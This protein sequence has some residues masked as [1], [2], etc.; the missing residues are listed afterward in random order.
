[1]SPTPGRDADFMPLLSCAENRPGHKALAAYNLPAW[2]QHPSIKRVRPETCLVFPASCGDGWQDL[3]ERCLQ[4]EAV[5]PKAMDM[6]EL[7]E[8]CFGWGMRSL[9]GLPSEVDVERRVQLAFVAN[10]L[11]YELV[12][13]E[14]PQ[15]CDEAACVAGLL[16]AGELAALVAAEVMS[17]DQGLIV[18]QAISVAVRE[19]SLCRDVA[20]VLKGLSEEEARR[21]CLYALRQDEALNPESARLE[22]A[23]SLRPNTYVL[24]GSET[25]VAQLKLLV[26]SGRT[27][28]ACETSDAERPLERRAQQHNC[29]ARLR[30]YIFFEVTG[31]D[32]AV[33]IQNASAAD[34]FKM[35]IAPMSAIVPK[36]REKIE[37]SEAQSQ[38]GASSW[39]MTTEDGSSLEN[40]WIVAEVDVALQPGES[41]DT[42]IRD[43]ET[44]MLSDLRQSLGRQV[45]VVSAAE[46]SKLESPP[47]RAAEVA[48]VAALAASDSYT[49]T[50]GAKSAMTK[51]VTMDILPPEMAVCLVAV[52][53]SALEGVQRALACIPHQKL[54]KDLFLCAG[55]RVRS[56]GKLSTSMCDKLFF[57]RRA[58]DRVR[59]D[60]VL[61]GCLRYGVKRFYE[62]GLGRCSDASQEAH[63]DVQ[64]LRFGSRDRLDEED[65]TECTNTDGTGSES[66]FLSAASEEEEDLNEL[67]ATVQ[68][69][70]SGL[71]GFLDR[72]F[73]R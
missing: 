63:A 39:R 1:M 19:R 4:N 44:K 41:R 17:F 65:V 3:L 43:M 36:V 16:A 20:A 37:G 58:D 11:A 54:Q 14:Q 66:S 21:L 69:R 55:W 64:V 46:A 31:V 30:S 47:R 28:G 7:A 62:C 53:R 72:I 26:S 29:D 27:T 9:P 8:Q 67:G 71:R 6:L 61:L 70:P 35:R 40:F 18:M 38:F 10:C 2:V 49:Q 48:E 68:S 25:T 60:S 32:K 45:F 5:A 59:W 13:I 33:L 15:S 57:R 23:A 56:G 73:G 52:S 24:V 34:A 50:E 12:K 51:D 22:Q 42:H